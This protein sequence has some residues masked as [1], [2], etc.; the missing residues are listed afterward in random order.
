V[1]RNG[2]E[3]RGRRA[4]GGRRSGRSRFRGVTKEITLPFSIQGRFAGP[5][6][7]DRIGIHETLAFNRREFGMAWTSNAEAKVAGNRVTVEIS[8]LA[9]RT[10]PDAKPKR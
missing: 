4:A 3:R 5:P 2:G 1:G 10:A 8:L 9:R 7:D 6:P